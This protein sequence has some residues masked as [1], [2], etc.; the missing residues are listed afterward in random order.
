LERQVCAHGY[1]S[2]V[3]AQESEAYFRSRP[4]GSRLAAWVSQQSSV[5]AS[6][7]VLEQRLEEVKA[8]FPGDDIP[9]PPHWGGYVI[10]LETIE[11]WQGRSSRLHDRLQFVRRADEGWDLRRLS[12]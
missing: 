12:P 1:V 4:H 3:S 11:F 7:A 10:H 6:R 9:L 8:R 2:K 5:I